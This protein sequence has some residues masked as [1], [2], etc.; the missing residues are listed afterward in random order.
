MGA[1]VTATSSGIGRVDVEIPGGTGLPPAT[2][3]GEVLYSVNGTSFTARL[4]VTSDEGW[5]VNNDGILIVNGFDP[6][7]GSPFLTSKVRVLVMR[8]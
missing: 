4:P 2:Q 6:A 1:G 3:V 5:L 7:I 8:S